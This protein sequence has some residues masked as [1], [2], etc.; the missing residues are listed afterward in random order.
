MVKKVI[1][2][3]VVLFIVVLIGIAVGYYKYILDDKDKNTVMGKTVIETIILFGLLT[4][5]SNIESSIGK[6]IIILVLSLLINY[7]NYKHN[8]KKCNYPSLFDIN[9]LGRSSIII[10]IITFLS[11]YNIEY[12]V[13]DLFYGDITKQDDE[14]K[15]DTGDVKLREIT[16]KDCSGLES[17]AKQACLRDN[18]EYYLRSDDG[19]M[20]DDVYA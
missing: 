12:N 20:D 10:I 18:Q 5:L 4:T 19:G 11:W 2:W 1:L 3:R 14:Y 13:F 6:V 17:E 9:L 16:E 15:D 7:Y 8:T